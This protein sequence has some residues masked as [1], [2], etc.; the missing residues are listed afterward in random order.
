LQQGQRVLVHAGAGGV[1]SF[2]IQ[3][4]RRAG[5][6]V[7]ATTSAAN[8][9]LARSLGAHEVIDYRSQGFAHLSDIDLVVD[10][11]GGETLEKSWSILR[12]RGRIATLIDFAIRPTGDKSGEFVFFKGATES[13]PDAMKLF[14]SGDLQIVIDSMFPLNEVRAGLKKVATGHA[15]GKV[16]IRGKHSF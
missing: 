2:A 4:A 9:E 16:I 7:V 1:G 12:A 6:H 10:T 8:L 11:I 5:A 3:L 14:S 15:R 13:L